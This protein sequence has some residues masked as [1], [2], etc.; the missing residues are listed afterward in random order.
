M[1][2]LV[3]LAPI[4]ALPV[5]WLLPSSVAVPIYGAVL[6]LTALIAWPVVVAWRRPQMTGAE[7][8]I[9][10]KAE[11]L[12]ELNPHGLVRCQ[13]EVWSATA[14]EPIPGSERVRV[15]AVDRLHARVT[16]YVPVKAQA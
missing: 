5:F 7:G 1:C 3:L 8:M 9:G 13:G 6:V 11:T 15:L 12:T 14:N 16:R 4:L 2:H 10:A